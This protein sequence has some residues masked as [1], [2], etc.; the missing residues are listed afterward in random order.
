MLAGKR[1][2]PRNVSEQ[3]NKFSTG[4]MILLLLNAIYFTFCIIIPVTDRPVAFTLFSVPAAC[5]IIAISAF[6]SRNLKSKFANHI[7]VYLG[8]ASGCV[9]VSLIFKFAGATDSAITS[10]SLILIA[11]LATMYFDHTR[12]NR[13]PRSEA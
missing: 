2:Q 8:I 6:M 9:A 1:S 4:M 3:M 10:P 13:T 5:A 12:S 7:P 11:I